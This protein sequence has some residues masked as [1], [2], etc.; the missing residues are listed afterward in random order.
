MNGNGCPT[1]WVLRSGKKDAEDSSGAGRGS[2]W[3]KPAGKPSSTPVVDDD[4]KGSGKRLSSGT[5]DSGS[6]TTS[7]TPHLGQFTTLPIRDREAPSSF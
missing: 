5:E 1:V 2:V 6:G 3:I 7:S 4:G